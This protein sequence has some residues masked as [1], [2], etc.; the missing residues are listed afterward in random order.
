[1]YIHDFYILFILS[2]TYTISINYK[3]YDLINLNNY[4]LLKNTLFLF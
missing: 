3:F 1:M 4:Q 2:Q